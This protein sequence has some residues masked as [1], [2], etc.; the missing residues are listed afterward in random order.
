VAPTATVPCLARSVALVALGCPKNLVD[1][2]H[3]LGSF[4][5]AGYRVTT[6]TA[7]ADVVVVTTCAFLEAAVRESNDAIRR[8]LKARNRRPG[9]RVVVAGCL[10][11]RLKTLPGDMPEGIDLL[12]DLRGMSHIPE[13]LDP[14]LRTRK[15][16]RTPT[17]GVGRRRHK[18]F[19]RLLSTPSHYAYLKIA[20]GCDNRCTYCLIPSIRGP[21]RSRPI[22]EIIREARSLARLGVKEIVLVAQDT[23][24]YGRDI[25]RRPALPRLLRRL[26]EIRRIRWIR[27]MYTHPAH[28]DASLLDAYR[29]NPKLCRYIDLPIQHVSDRILGHMNRRYT[30]RV[31]EDLLLRLRTIPE[32]RIRTTVI[33]G[34]P[35]E[36]EAEFRELLDFLGSA[37]F[38]RLGAYAYS[39]EPG[40]AAARLSAQLPA[41]LRSRRLSR[42]MATQAAISRGN[43]RRLKARTLKVLMD[44]PVTGRTEWDA[45][46]IDGIVRLEGGT[47]TPG[48]LVAAR[49][50]RT[51]THD[52]IARPLREG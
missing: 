31:L 37:R 46:E 5:L 39:P 40:T 20:D 6:D 22:P 12:V 44:S 41:E 32:M 42:V 33:V 14:E 34:F 18:A 28:V 2:E 25:Y 35:G 8:L 13:L 1:S 29:S 11:E 48:S 23:S 38:D 51:L 36:T 21:R 19:P 4:A 45:P 10:V 16:A 3:V 27:L 30:R 26:A 9:Q 24:A 50:I 15:G 52:L 7:K 17:G 47:G 49:V 43:L